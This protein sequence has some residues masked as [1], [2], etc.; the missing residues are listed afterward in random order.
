M[1]EA[2][3]H[4]DDFTTVFDTH[5]KRVYNTVLSLLQNRE[6]TEDVVQEVFI[7]VYETLP[8]FKGESSLST[9]IYRIAVNKSLDALKAK[10][11][12]KRSGFLV[13]LFGD[14]KDESKPLDVPDFV[15]PGVIAENKELATTLFKA[16]N[17]LPDNQKVAFT[18]CKMDGLNYAEIAEVM[19]V[20]TPS[21]ESLL[22]RAKQ[23]LQKQ[24]RT[25][26]ENEVLM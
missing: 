26:Y 9:W 19:Q 16:I 12:K 15:H 6:E 23:N 1:N 17:Q 21:V 8:Q 18:L 24:L 14:K 13:S 10:K 7:K 11:T 2:Q 25:F 3:H 22:F 4:T 20:S 5:K